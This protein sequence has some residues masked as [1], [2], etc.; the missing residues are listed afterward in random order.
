MNAAMQSSKSGGPLAGAWAVLH[1][2]GD[3]GYLEIA[4][5]LLAEK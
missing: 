1:F 4:R 3:E 5:R 2:I